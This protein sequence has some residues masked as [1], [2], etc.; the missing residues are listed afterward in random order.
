MLRNKNGITLVAL[1]ITVIIMLI[2]VVVT[3]TKA[4]EGGLFNETKNARSSTEIEKD[5]ESLL[6]ATA[7]ALDD[8]GN[9]DPTLL[10]LPEGFSGSN[11][12]YTK[13]GV[14]F[15]VN[16]YGSVIV[17]TTSS[18]Y[19]IGDEVT[20]AGLD[21]YVIDQNATTLTLFSGYNTFGSI[22]LTKSSHS[23][24]THSN[25]AFSGS[26]VFASQLQDQKDYI[27]DLWGHSISEIRCIS[28]SEII[29]L[30]GSDD[31]VNWAIYVGANSTIPSYLTGDSYWIDSELG[32]P[33]S[34]LYCEPTDSG[35]YVYY[36]TD[37]DDPPRY[38][39]PVIVINKSD[40]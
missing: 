36:D 11:G 33:S 13:D 31:E 17:Q 5:K 25:S 16:Q 9:F 26:T 22:G 21:F 32:S 7:G 12:T 30:I 18:A 28:L 29:N 4:L 14:T 39:R 10:I 24:G 34:S 20:L 37:Y 3:V 40:L 8:N 23:Q 15:R 27:E 6:S 35:L 1:I 19:Q 2:L 38:L